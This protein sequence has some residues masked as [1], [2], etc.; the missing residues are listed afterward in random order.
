MKW[1]NA[2]DRFSKRKNK[3]GSYILEAVIVIPIFIVAVTALMSI[4][5]ITATCE[6]MVFAA[7]DEMR[8]ESVKC[9]FR[10]NPAALPVMAEHRI[11]KENT[12]LTAYR[13]SG[14]RYLYENNGIED[15]ISLSFEAEFSEK[16]PV[17]LFQSVI[18]GGSI[19]G[20]AFTG[21]LHKKPP[22]EGTNFPEEDEIVCIFPE[23]GKRYHG[24]NCT[25]VKSACKMTYLSQDTKKGLKPCELCNASQAQIGSPVFYFPASGNAY[26]TGECRTVERYYVE[27]GKKD[28]VQKGYTP[29]T[30]C[31]GS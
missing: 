27:I 12:K 7:A 9:A 20:R 28:A 2:I 8:L 24:K 22:D 3:K 1:L 16:N 21:K 31:G 18:F 30:K 13:T 26:H 25:Y 11:R 14:Y 23:W 17:V 19:T 15:L 5:P 29:C 10:E 6:N 4:V